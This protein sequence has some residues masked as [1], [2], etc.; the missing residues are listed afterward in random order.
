MEGNKSNCKESVPLTTKAIDYLINDEYS[1]IASNNNIN[2]NN[3]N[4][5]NR[6]KKSKSNVSFEDIDENNENNEFVVSLNND[7]LNN[8]Y[9]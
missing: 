6:T 5:N 1:I 3:I 8:D 9:Q 2:N 7:I 4:N